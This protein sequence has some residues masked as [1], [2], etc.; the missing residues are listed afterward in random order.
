MTLAEGTAD[1]L[2]RL[3]RLC[4]WREH[5]K[6]NFSALEKRS[7]LGLIFFKGLKLFSEEIANSLRNAVRSLYQSWIGCPAFSGWNCLLRGSAACFPYTSQ[8]S[9]RSTVR[10]CCGCP[11]FSVRCP[12]DFL[13]SS[14]CLCCWDGS[15]NGK[16][17]EKAFLLAWSASKRVW[18]RMGW[19]DG[20]SVSHGIIVQVLLWILVKFFLLRS[21]VTLRL[22]NGDVSN[23]TPKLPHVLKLFCGSILC[24]MARCH[25]VTLLTC[26]MRFLTLFKRCSLTFPVSFC[27]VPET[28]KSASTRRVFNPAC[29]C[30]SLWT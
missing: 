23:Q 11:G 5:M 24:F 18:S 21:N 29:L 3:W 6:S 10:S 9:F 4:G 28:L 19:L 27:Q 2:G 14:F 13:L 12:A 30:A 20:S 7:Q 17:N 26:Q 8:V 1:F 25:C 22:P 16:I 15:G